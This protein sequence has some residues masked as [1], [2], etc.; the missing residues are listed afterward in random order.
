MI[1]YQFLEKEG[2]VGSK[3]VKSLSMVMFMKRITYTKVKAELRL[4]QISIIQLPVLHSK[5]GRHRPDVSSDIS[6][7]YRERECIILY[8]YTYCLL[9]EYQ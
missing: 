1:Y 7:E 4:I 2:A 5:R 9:I 6:L 3:L 8:M